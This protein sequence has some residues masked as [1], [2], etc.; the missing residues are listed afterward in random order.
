M[1]SSGHVNKYLIDTVILL[2]RYSYSPRRIATPPPS[3]LVSPISIMYHLK[4]PVRFHSTI[5]EIFNLIPSSV[6]ADGLGFFD[7]F[8]PREVVLDQELAR[9]VNSLNDLL[10]SAEYV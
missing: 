2:H 9:I 5:D 3:N 4:S 8:T 10:L 6:A 1:F 7:L